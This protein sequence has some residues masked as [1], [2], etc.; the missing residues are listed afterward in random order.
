M[1][2]AADR[3]DKTEEASEKKRQ[4]SLER[5]DAPVSR[6]VVT[7]AGLAGAWV[8]IVFVAPLQA[9]QAT[10]RL[11]R[12][13]EGAHAIR[14]HRGED[15]GALLI[16]V[17]REWG[18]PL[19][20]LLAPLALMV[21]AAHVAQAKPRIVG[22]RLHPQWS[23]LSPR[24]GWRRLF[25]RQGGAQAL[26]TLARVAIA[27]IAVAL[28]ARAL[29]EPVLGALA[30][31]PALIAGDLLGA[32]DGVLTTT[33]IAVTLA[34]AADILLSRL[35]WLKGLR[36]T[37]AEVKEE[38]RQAEGDPHVRQRQRSLRLQRARR[39]MIAA[40]PKATLVIA[41]PTHY[42]IALRYVRGETAAPLVLAKGVD[43]LALRIRGL[44]EAHRIPVIEDK[45]LARSMYDQV[46]VEKMIPP[47]FY[48]AVAA[49]V[50][51]VNKSAAGRAAKH[52]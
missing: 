32:V 43:H 9:P 7:A 48:E 45:A 39:R 6:D 15:V 19:L 33:L 17:M 2:E 27:F 35:H 30:R 51:T 52:P 47:E 41:N 31:P 8:A 1:S 25:G 20:S 4:D 23:R 13:L 24:Q 26:R 21:I 34:A 12:L 29:V 18:L 44:A 16:L 46:T 36:M 11:G 50:H 14:L 28:A 22:K 3:D 5:G 42:A 49:V 40:V 10:V 37:R 38:H